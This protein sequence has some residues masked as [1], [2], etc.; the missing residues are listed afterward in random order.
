MSGNSNCT[1]DRSALARFGQGRV[2]TLGD[3]QL[4]VGEVIRNG[5]PG[6]GVALLPWALDTYERVL[7][8]KPEETW[9]LKRMLKHA[10]E[11]DTSVFLSLHKVTREANITRPRLRRI[12]TRLEEL[13]YITRLE[14][15]DSDQRRHYSVR[16]LYDALALC[17]A[18]DPKSKWAS[19]H[20][21]LVPDGYYSNGHGVRYQLDF[22]RRNGHAVAV[23]G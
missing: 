17:I 8:L 20:G 19:E 22:A 18:A 4:D 23:K 16:G 11:A 14:S 9:L 5:G 13:G 10:W 6:E 12:L 2:W 15:E 3:I 7:R 1:G 21:V